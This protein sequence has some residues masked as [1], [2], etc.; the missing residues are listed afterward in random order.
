MRGN[1][2]AVVQVA[3]R[4]RGVAGVSDVA[5]DLAG[6]HDLS[7]VDRGVTV[8]VGVVVPYQSWTEHFDDAASQ[9]IHADDEDDAWRR[10]DHACAAR[11]K[12]VDAFMTPPFRPRCS[13]RIDQ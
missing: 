11:G 12:N 3:W 5:E 7:G 1:V 10:A 8:K 6:L 4:S 2:H 13:P 9:A